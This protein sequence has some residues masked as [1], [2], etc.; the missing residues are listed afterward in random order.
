MTAEHETAVPD[1]VASQ[2]PGAPHVPG[3][4][5]ANWQAFRS[6]SRAMFRGFTRDRAAM[7]F[8]ILF[9]VM[10]LLLFGSIYKS[11]STPRINVVEVGAAS[12]LDQARTASHGQLDRVLKI[13]H[14]ASLAAALNDVRQGN[15][16]AA[17]QQ[18]GG[19]LVVHYS[20]ANPTTAGVVTSVFSGI[21]QAANQAASRRPPTYQLA[22][23]Q[24]EDKSLKPIQYIT[25]GLLGWAIASGAAFAAAITLVSWRENKLLRRLR[26]APVSTA[27]IVTARIAVSVAV[28]IIQMFVFIAIATTPYFGLKLTAY[29]W[30]AIPL[31]ICGTLAFLSIGLLV[32]ALAKTQ[33]A[34]TALANLII[35]P[36]AF[37]GG[38]FIPLTFAPQ[39]IQNVSYVMPLRYLVV[40]MQNVM[41]RGD[42][43]AAALPAMGILLAFAAVLTLISVRVFRWDEI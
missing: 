25:P 1:A 35:L 36:M 13:T 39:W 22:A 27:S 9:P 41:A 18:V 42:G 8:S 15:V 5:N 6:L 24:V 10:F 32:G 33:Q 4:G 30:M 7:F 38:A 23:R 17:V 40:G 43:P 16:D 2:A 29:W 12:V 28:G 20:V 3:R 14:K 19:R 37:L 34:A 21:V 31:V 11:S 26:L